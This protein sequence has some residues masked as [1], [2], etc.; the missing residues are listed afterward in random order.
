VH[1]AGR[2]NGARPTR[3]C[4]PTA[5]ISSRRQLPHAP[6]AIA[7]LLAAALVPLAT[8][9]EAG[10]TV[11]DPSL[12]TA[13]VLTRDGGEVELHARAGHGRRARRR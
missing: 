13:S 8:I 3:W 9:S 5:A 11:V 1:I 10:P 2:S 6:I 7:D 12:S 4:S